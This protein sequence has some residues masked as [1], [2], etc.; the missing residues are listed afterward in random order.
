MSKIIIG[1]GK[2]AG[3]SLVFPERPTIEQ[4]LNTPNQQTF[5][6]DFNGVSW[7]LTQYQYSDQPDFANPTLEE[8]AG[9]T[10][11]IIAS[12]NAIDDF[13]IQARGKNNSGKLG[14]WTDTLFIDVPNQVAVGNT[15]PQVTNGDAELFINYTT[16]AVGL[17]DVTLFYKV[18]GDSNFIENG[19]FPPTGNLLLSG[20]TNGTTYEVQI[21]HNPI[22]FDYLES[23]SSILEGTP[24]VIVQQLPTPQSSTFAQTSQN[25]G[26]FI[27]ATVGQATGYNYY[28]ND[29][30]LASTASTNATIDISGFSIGTQIKLSVEATAAGFTTSERLDRN[31]VI[32]DFAANVITPEQFGAEPY[33]KPL[34]GRQFEGFDFPLINYNPL[35]EAQFNALGTG[36]TY[37]DYPNGVTQLTPVTN[38]GNG[39]TING[40]FTSDD[41]GKSFV[42]LKNNLN[43]ALGNFVDE[44]ID[45]N[46]SARYATVVFQDLGFALV[47]FEFNGNDR[48]A[49]QQQLNGKGYIFND[50]TSALNQVAVNWKGASS[51]DTIRL[52]PNVR[53]SYVLSTYVA[54]EFEGFDLDGTNN[55]N[56]LIYTGSTARARIKYAI[57]DYNYSRVPTGGAQKYVQTSRL[58]N[59]NGYTGQCVSHNIQWVS[60]H[61]SFN[62]ASALRTDFA[63]GRMGGGGVCLGVNI[64]N[65]VEWDELYNGYEVTAADQFL[66]RAGSLSSNGTTTGTEDETKDVDEF[67][68]LAFTG[69]ADFQG[70]QSMGQTSGYTA[71]ATYYVFDDFTTNIIPTGE[72]G[73]YSTSFDCK[74]ST[75]YTGIWDT[76]DDQDPS[77]K[78]ELP[79]HSLEIIPKLGDGNF[80]IPRTW[81][82]NNR[83]MI[84][85]ID[86]FVFAAN[87]NR[88]NYI[89]D[90]YCQ[91]YFPTNSKLLATDDMSNGDKTIS[92][93]KAIV[94][95]EIPKVGEVRQISRDYLL[96]NDMGA[97][98]NR[99]FATVGLPLRNSVRTMSNWCT[100]L[101]KYVDDFTQ[102]EK[103]YIYEYGKPIEMQVGDEFKLCSWII[104]SDAT[105]L[106]KGDSVTGDTSGATATVERVEQIRYANRVV[107]KGASASFDGDS[108]I[109]G[110]AYTITSSSDYDPTEVYK[111]MRKQ[112]GS[113]P[114]STEQ[115][116]TDFN[117]E[118]WTYYGAGDYAKGI[119]VNASSNDLKAYQWSYLMLDKTLPDGVN[120]VGAI[121]D[122]DDPTL[123][124]EIVESKAEYLLDGQTRRGRLTYV[125]QAK[126]VNNYVYYN[127]VNRTA[128]ARSGAA[129]VGYGL[130]FGGAEDNNINGFD[131]QPWLYS[132]AGG[133]QVAYTRAEM[134]WYLRSPSNWQRTAYRQNRLT[135]EGNTSQMRPAGRTAFSLNS[136]AKYSKGYTLINIE[137]IKKILQV[138]KAG[139]S[140]QFDNTQVIYDNNPSYVPQYAIDEEML[141][142]TET[143]PYVPKI[144][145]YGQRTIDFINTELNEYSN[146]TGNT[147]LTDTDVNNAPDLPKTIRDILATLPS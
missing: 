109:N 48:D 42:G 96:G 12:Q 21:R 62:I 43:G 58:F 92:S 7:D 59:F 66:L 27:W 82:G 33:Y 24:S 116:V 13:Y 34:D 144:R 128:V 94:A 100:I 102:A 14:E 29:I 10:I 147:V 32:V 85:H 90:Y 23:F 44:F 60:A 108:T 70:P 75:D 35:T 8:T 80:W 39:T 55:K 67:G 37:A 71:G 91:F 137:G 88:D 78:T 104:V 19:T 57:E 73:T 41:V 61:N 16:S 1:T 77:T 132:Q 122:K 69:L 65:M 127:G 119:N 40:V 103:D 68:F 38:D 52:T 72:Y 26:T 30:F 120:G 31:Y 79:S 3:G 129:Q 106:S 2:N 143:A 130:A 135:S 105:G 9:T 136:L 121:A 45:Y 20:L 139:S 131:S 110:G 114:L 51:P 145:L 50:D 54:P 22:N 111:C 47:D 101:N 124:I 53:N 123:Y 84:Y 64:E 142:P 5:T 97:N 56:L 126:Y 125:G 76:G 93:T 81:G 141:P 107:L 115:T 4:T 98:D 74:F 11:D 99:T 138:E 28:V 63:Y 140:S 134:S 112:R 87:T 49:S 86:D 95:W 6:V 89:T 15:F 36:L 17:K 113:Y 118:E 133:W 25:D 117:E 18:K 46:I 83:T 146:V